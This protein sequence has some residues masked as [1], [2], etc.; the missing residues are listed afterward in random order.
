M[1]DPARFMK[2]A[3]PWRRPLQIALVMLLTAISQPG[4][5]ANR[6]ETLAR[7]DLPHVEIS[8]A[9]LVPAGLF[10]SSAPTVAGSTPAAL[11]A[12][13]EIKAIAR[14]T[15]DS[16]IGI[17]IWLPVAD[18]NGR[19]Q[20]VGNGGW[21]G[22][23]H[24]RPLAEALRRGYATAATDDGHTGGIDDEGKGSRSAEFAIGHPE[25]LIDFGYR[26]LAETQRV[27]LAAIEAFYGHGAAKSYF[28]G[29]SDG[30][31][32]ALMIAQRMPEA[33][34]GIL[35]G[36]P[37][38]DWSHWAAGLVWNEQAQAEGTPGAIPP[39]KRAFIQAAVLAACD[40]IDGVTDGL[41][42]DPRFCH[43]NPTA[44]ICKGADSPDC[45][46]AAQVTTLQKIY[47]GPRHPRSG[48]P[49]F[50]GFPPGIEN[51]PG[52]AV[53]TPWSSDLSSFGDTYFGQLVFGRSAWDFRSLDFDR[54]IA[55]SDR[56][57]S[58]IVDAIN[59]DLRAF[60]AH[61]GK[62]IQYHG[63][64]DPLMPAGGSIAYHQRVAAF[65]TS[66]INRSSGGTASIADFYRLFMI[67]GM[68]HCYGG[69]GPTAITSLDAGTEADPEYDLLQ[70]L[71]RW[72]E[73]S[74]PP[75]RFI[76]SGKAPYDRTK[77]MTRPICAFPQVARYKGHGDINAAS[78]FD[79]SAPPGTDS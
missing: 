5:A 70:S 39:S 60:R 44:L 15:P 4:F 61:G 54:D 73:H 2:I 28:V 47:D 33:F 67:P 7:L 20:Q 40:A 9:S 30:G 55:L 24:R 68:G 19:Y 79:C 65:M 3:H 64:S 16:E 43:F 22:A 76:G 66:R 59:P 38:N 17:E 63:W 6:C 34:D 69:D 1:D 10:A 37:G 42:S 50:P 36:N 72:V 62:L 14:P 77:T 52:L 27:A 71:E 18:W 31:R 23:I 21:A 11:A 35:A 51:T 56:K 74:V 29:C 57:I 25:K 45:L 53:I 48:V 12:H 13:C 46:T 32:E 41:I 49:I 75:A 26:A 78:N 58:P 8:S